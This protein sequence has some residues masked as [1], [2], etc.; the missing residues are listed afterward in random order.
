MVVFEHVA[1]GFAGPQGKRVEA[2]RDFNLEVNARELLVLVGPS[3][4]GKT[5][6]LRM[7]AGLENPEAGTIRL[8]GRSLAG[9][10]PKERDVAMVFQQPALFPHL[11]VFQ[12]IGF[13]LMLRKFPAAEIKSRVTEAAEMLHIS[14]LL[15]RKPATLSG[16]EAQRVAL[17]R[18]LARK[19]KVFLLDEPLSNL[20]A[21]L[22]VQLRGEIAALQRRLG[23]TMLFVTHDQTE[24]MALADRVAVIHE[25]IVQQAAAPAEIRARP[26]NAFVAQF[27]AG[28]AT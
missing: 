27:L 3:G 9:V 13:G 16:G 6:A 11:T 10:K 15:E 28:A 14:G 19:P 2:L 18:A 24:A 8:E 12:N 22:R 5:T 23:V 17:G 25:G 21:P 4:S 7:L 26:A 20:D 1:R